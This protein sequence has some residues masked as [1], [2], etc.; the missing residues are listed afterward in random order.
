MM[1]PLR[2]RYICRSAARV[3]R[4]APSRWMASSRFQSANGSSSSGA[5]IWIP[6]LLT[7]TSIRPK[8]ETAA[9]MPDSTSDSLVTSIATAMMRWPDPS[10]CSAVACAAVAF[11]SAITTLAPA[12]ANVRAISLPMPLAAPVTTA[13]F[14]LS[15]IRLAPYR[16]WVWQRDSI[17]PVLR[18]VEGHD[19]LEVVRP[20]ERL[21]M[22]QGAHR[23]VIACAPV[24]L[25][26]VTREFIVLGVAL[27]LLGPIDELDEVVYLGARVRLQQRDFGAV[28]QLVGKLV[29][30]ARDGIAQLLGV[31]EAV[32]AAARATRVLNLFLP[33]HH[34][35][36][37]A[38]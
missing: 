11:R 12:A 32:R 20:G 15:C 4:K 25:H 37:R 35:G 3:V 38:R 27:V 1:L 9:A 36:H 22:A 29:Q 18:E 16:S 17:P 6:A 23:I 14:S 30:Q 7:R 31:A 24:V 26:A 33:R 2:C 34:L 8:A 19:A 21:G 10:S 5:T 28:A 13:T